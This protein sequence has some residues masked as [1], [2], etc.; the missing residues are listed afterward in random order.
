[1]APHTTNRHAGETAPVVAHGLLTSMAVVS[2]G[3]MTLWEHWADLS[4]E[5]RDYLFERILAHTTFV[6]DTL[7][8]LTRGLPEGMAAE[9]DAMH[10][11]RPQHPGVMRSLGDPPD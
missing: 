1:M 9:L 4:P 5:K 2:A 3:A 8:D 6:A 10:Q 11:R 7:K